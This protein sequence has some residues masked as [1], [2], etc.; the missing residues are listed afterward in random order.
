MP[1]RKYEQAG[2]PQE[3]GGRDAHEGK[4]DEQQRGEQHGRRRNASQKA[5]GAAPAQGQAQIARRQAGHLPQKEDV[6]V[7]RPVQRQ[8]AVLQKNFRGEEDKKIQR[9]Q[10]SGPQRGDV[11]TGYR[12]HGAWA[13]QMDGNRQDVAYGALGPASLP[14]REHPTM[15]EGHAALQIG[16]QPTPPMR[17]AP[18]GEHVWDIR[19]RTFLGL[20]SG[21]LPV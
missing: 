6:E 19:R 5:V 3:Q 8:Q 4:G 13:L 14:S 7:F 20:S 16:G 1:P 10:D 12:A 15:A 9:K 21:A 2:G 18:G 11:G 17:T